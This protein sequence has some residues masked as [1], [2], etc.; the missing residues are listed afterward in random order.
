MN[1]TDRTIDPARLAELLTAPFPANEVRWKP[2]A[3]SGNRALA[4]CHIDARVWPAPRAIRCGL[5]APSLP[6]L[7]RIDLTT[8]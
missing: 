2:Q 6:L 7:G 4:I 1:T 5:P 8:R 3:V